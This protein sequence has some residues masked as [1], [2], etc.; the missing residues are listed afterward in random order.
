ML[1]V[2]DRYLLKEVMHGWLA[3]SLIL[4]LILV[5]NRLAR[6]L[7]AAAAGDMPADVIFVLLG[8]KVFLLLVYVLP[9][10][11]ALGVMLG[12][13]RLYRDSEMVVLGACG[14]GLR[15]L[16]RPLL[17]LALVTTMLLTWVAL[18]VAPKAAAI[19]YEVLARAEQTAEVSMLGAGRFQ[20]VRGG[21]LTFF[22][23][24]LSPDHERMENIFIH[25]RGRRG[26]KPSQLL[27]ARSAYV[28]RDETTGG[29][30]LVLVDG[31]R[32]EGDP[33]Q[34]D[35]KVMKFEKHGVRIDINKAVAANFKKDAMPT[36]TLLSSDKPADIAELQ[37][38]VSVP[39]STLVLMILAIP[40]S[41]GNPR[42]GRYGRIVAAVLLFIIYN[43]L[44]STAQAW[45]EQGVL[46]PMVGLWWVHLLPVML[47]VILVNW[48]KLVCRVRL[49]A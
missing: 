42:Q 23:E 40:L 13:G 33:G 11:L 28:T 5:S 35:Y 15:G 45:V 48:Q 34:A 17:A 18:Y 20:Q 44:L 27:S 47:A 19:G 41:Q 29:R 1:Q 8:L 3:V 25:V 43:N 21:L 30:F 38:R 37:W 36:G 7:A 16:Y 22:A 4:C 6:Y 14:V 10:S 46:P 2:V 9:F 24:R 49:R 32:Y 26:D 31:Y 12:L 39:V